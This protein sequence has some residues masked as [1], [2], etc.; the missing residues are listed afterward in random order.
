LIKETCGDDSKSGSDNGKNRGDKGAS[1]IS[2][3]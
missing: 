3:V 2:Y 1:C